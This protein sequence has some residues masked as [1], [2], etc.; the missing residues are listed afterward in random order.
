MYLFTDDPLLFSVSPSTELCQGSLYG[1]YGF[2]LPVQSNRKGTNSSLLIF[3]FQQ[4]SFN[5]NYLLGV[6][7]G[8]GGAASLRFLLLQKVAAA[9]C[10]FHATGFWGHQSKI[11]VFSQSWLHLF[12]TALIVPLPTHLAQFL[13]VRL[14]WKKTSDADGHVLVAGSGGRR[15][16]RGT[17]LQKEAMLSESLHMV[18]LIQSARSLVRA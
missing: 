7:G 2:V 15:W 17:L 5:C 14:L 13:L 9:D 12:S 3:E 11:F 1:L 16:R 10:G 8:G 6:G 4:L 18:L